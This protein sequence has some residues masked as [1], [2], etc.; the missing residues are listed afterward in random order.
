[1][2]TATATPVAVLNKPKRAK[3]PEIL[4]SREESKS[5]LGEYAFSLVDEARSS[6]SELEKTLARLDAEGVDTETFEDAAFGRMMDEGRTGKYVS[7][8]HVMKSLRRL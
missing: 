5:L 6:D 7:W 3:K 8:E 1:M 2:Q 4:M